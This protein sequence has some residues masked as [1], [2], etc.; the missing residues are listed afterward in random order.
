MGLEQQIMWTSSVA[1]E[2]EIESGRRH[3][4]LVVMIDMLEIFERF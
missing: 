4:L 2:L 3:A 1:M